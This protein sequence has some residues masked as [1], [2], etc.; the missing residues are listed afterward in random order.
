MGVSEGPVGK[1]RRCL[2][3][4]ARDQGVGDVGRQSGQGVGGEWD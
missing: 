4:Q 3:V 2:E 1:T